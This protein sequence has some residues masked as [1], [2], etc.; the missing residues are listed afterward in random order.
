MPHVVYLGLLIGCPWPGCGC[1]IEMIDFR[2]EAVGDPA[3]Y[4]R[5]MTDWGRSP[6]YGLVGR[7]PG[8]GQYVLYGLTD[9]QPVS[10]PTATSL[11]VLPDD[12][13]LNAYIA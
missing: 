10:D 1:R 13:H 4:A 2:L 6:G 5:V 11:P 9:K 3:L 8:C 12:W 7:C